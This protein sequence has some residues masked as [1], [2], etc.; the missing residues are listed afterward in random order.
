MKH[1]EAF[2]NGQPRETGNIGYTGHK[3]KK[4]KTKNTT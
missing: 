1:E 4:N 2:K 3:T